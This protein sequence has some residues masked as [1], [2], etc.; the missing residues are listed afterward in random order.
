[1]I[2]FNRLLVLSSLLA[3]TA[4]LFSCSSGGGTISNLPS[5]PTI[6]DG[7]AAYEGDKEV[8]KLSLTKEGKPFLEVNGKPMLMLGSQLR[9]D[10]FTKLD[11]LALY[12]LD[13]YFELAKTLNITMVQVPVCWSDVEIEK[14]TYDSTYVEKMMYFAKKYDFK[15][16]IL[17][18]GSYMCG[19]SVEKYLPTYINRDLDTYPRLSTNKEFDGWLG[20]HGWLDPRNEELI[21]REEKAIAK[22]MDFVY[23][24]DRYHGGTCIVS[25]V[26]VENEPD[27]LLSIHYNEIGF[28]KEVEFD[29]LKNGLFNL[30]DRVGQKVKDSKYKCYTR[31]NM[32]VNSGDYL[33]FSKELCASE[34]VDFVGLDPYDNKISALNNYLTELKSIP[35]NFAHIAENGGEYDNN[36]S[37]ELKAF[38]SGCGYEVFEVVTTPN[39]L[40]KDWTLRGVYNPDFTKKSQTDDLI[41]ANKIFRSGYVD[42][43]ISEL[44]NMEGFNI[45]SNNT[46]KNIKQN[47]ELDNG[48]K[49][50]FSSENYGLG[51]CAF[52]DDH[53][54]FASTKNDTISFDGVNFSRVTYGS[55][56]MSGQWVEE[57]V[58]SNNTNINL[59]ATKVYR[60]IVR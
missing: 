36:P 51:Y 49:G 2:L 31:V 3:F 21:K 23:E 12:E 1:M 54:T 26:Q 41:D 35:G 58:V 17:W 52:A 45:M 29:A 30:I 14:N 42:L 37:L 43:A 55:Y 4:P 56:N 34:G 50:T 15:L 60:V 18:F 19:Y 57:G 47:F 40:L 5:E 46:M 48:I 24:Y 25:G 39:P 32:T 16:E 27:M 13:M 59:E 20:K 6:S 7:V 8:S 22:M 11:N 33:K 9:T 53:V 10:F 44:S 28:N 38:I